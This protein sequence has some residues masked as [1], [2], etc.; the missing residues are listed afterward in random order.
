[1]KLKQI[2]AAISLT[3]AATTAAHA[4]EVTVKVIAFNDFHG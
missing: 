3:L 2:A 1:M 4:G